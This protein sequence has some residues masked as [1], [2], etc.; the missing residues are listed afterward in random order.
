MIY[1]SA[2]KG[3]ITD[4]QI[5]L[6]GK[7]RK[8][9][10]FTL[11]QSID[12][13]PYVATAGSSVESIEISIDQLIKKEGAP[14]ITIDCDALAIAFKQCYLNQVYMQ[15][16]DLA[17]EFG[18]LKLDLTIIKLNFLDVASLTGNASANTISSLGLF[19]ANTQLTW[20]KSPSAKSP[21]I[22]SGK[23]TGP[24]RNDNLF[25]QEFDFEKM[26]IGGLGAQFQ[27]IFRKAFASRI[28]PGLLKEMGMSHVRGML[29]YGPPG[30]GKTLIA[31]QIGKVLN[32][33]EP[34]IVNGPEILDKFVGGSEE[35]VRALFADAEKEQ[36]LV[37]TINFVEFMALIDLKY[38]LHT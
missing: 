25:K 11:G 3:I 15:G 37:C 7:Q 4:D 19:S 17:M 16:Q 14:A 29:L 20:K 5:G 9:G 1:Y 10:Q 34:K 2:N 21:I 23:S 13:K 24:Q 28:F 27:T 30:C 22:L 12:V 38:I 8:L 31:R 36:V 32:A 26:G 6:N 35:K 18:A 33:R